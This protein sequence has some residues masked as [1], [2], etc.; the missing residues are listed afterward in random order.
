MA[1]HNEVRVLV[2]V[3][4]GEVPCSVNLS[5]GH[6]VNCTIH[7]QFS[8]GKKVTQVT[9]ILEVPLQMLNL[10]IAFLNSSIN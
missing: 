9:A 6:E 8:D 3:T 1:D 4:D 7:P 5:N 10:Q 2:F